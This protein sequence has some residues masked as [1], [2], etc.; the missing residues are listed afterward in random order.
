M[1]YKEQEFAVRA[2]KKAR[3]MWLTMAIILSASYLLEVIKGGK[4][5]SY[6]L[7]MI[8]FCWGPIIVGAVVLKVKGADTKLYKYVCGFGYIIFYMYIMFTSPGTLA[9]AYTLPL[10]SMLIIF[11]S[12]NFILECGVVNIAI[13]VF[14]IIRNYRNGM[15]A[16]T[17]IVTFEMQFGII[18]ICYIGYVIAINH[19]SN[20]DNAMIGAVKSN[21]QKV[22]TT[23]E[24]VK[25]ASNA[26]VDGVTVVREL[27]DENKEGAKAV[28][29]CMEN[30]AE[31]NAMLSQRIDSSMEMTTDIDSQVQ[32]VA[33]LI[34]HIVT[35]SE[36]SVVHANN[37]S[38]ELKNAVA[39][40]NDMAKLSSEVE[41]ILKEFRNHFD[42]VKQETGTIEGITSQTNLLALNASIEAARAGEA[43]KGFAV[44]ADEIRN[45]ST[46]TQTS[47]NSIMEA[48][49]LL[50]ET[51]DK[52]TQSITMI[53]KL[54]GESLER[55]QNVNASV[56]MINQE[57]GQIGG[58]IQVVDSAMKSVKNSN[59]NMVD[60]M[61]D[62]Q[63]IMINITEGVAEA[64]N[65]TATM[66]SKYEETMN[67]V[68][69]IEDVVG[70]L[71]EELGE[72]G[73]MNS[74]DISSGMRMLITDEQSQEKLQTEVTG[75]ADN[76]LFF[77]ATAT[78]NAFLSD[79]LKRNTFE[80]QITVNNTVYLWKQVKIQKHA[81]GY[82][83]QIESDPKVVNR[84]KYPRLPMTNS[85]DLVLNTSQSVFKGN[86]VNISAGGFSF[87][88]DAKE[89]AHAVGNM[90]K[91]TIHDFPLLK[92]K[93]LSGIIIRSSD[94]NGTYIVGCR[95]PE[96]HMDIMKYVKEKMGE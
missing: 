35:I 44:V 71:V 34:E 91:I 50:E 96:D 37:S 9:F 27:A 25:K 19:M 48:L 10:M 95:M 38:E 67:S 70:K 13:V 65:T 58:E 5:L 23:I 42:R 52:M 4:T 93:A 75:V 16:A 29:D 51:S 88:C 85:C 46:G 31:K 49:K 7:F 39:A 3:G 79:R 40:T 64:E 18:L 8:A 26:V 53:L 94:N 36:K 89:F 61:K 69:R 83:I 11:K 84:R 60:N 63:N 54:V 86:V 15:T 72:G 73:F 17:D 6:F 2:N 14:T 55:M 80:I 24:K 32:N 76:S 1:E 41:V 59:K 74:K 57:S 43:G 33:G 47:S 62:V 30:L 12:R 20:S 78:E 68:V 21:L 90:V 22:V 81:D 56:S 66:L 87:A 77:A 92:E 28:V 45:L 82:Q